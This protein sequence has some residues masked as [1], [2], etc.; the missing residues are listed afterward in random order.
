VISGVLDTRSASIHILAILSNNS[1]SSLF[2]SDPAI[3]PIPIL[4]LVIIATGGVTVGTVDGLELVVNK[5]GVKDGLEEGGVLVI[6]T[7]GFKVVEL[8]GVKLI[9]VEGRLV[10]DLDGVKLGSDEVMLVGD[11]VQRP[12]VIGQR[13]WV[14]KLEGEDSSLDAL[15]KHLAVLTLPTQAHDFLCEKSPSTKNRS[16]VSVL[17]SQ[18]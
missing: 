2:I 16:V 3:G 4:T 13:S 10:G 1:F 17:P 18:S 5:V 14:F 7:L 15:L 11:R 6:M 9:C 12:H 8:D